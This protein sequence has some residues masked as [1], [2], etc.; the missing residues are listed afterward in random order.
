MGKKKPKKGGIKKQISSFI[1]NEEG[2]I[3]KH[4]LT[5]MGALV[6]SAAAAALI[7]KSVSAGPVSITKTGSSTSFT[8][9]ASVTH[10]Y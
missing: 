8:V 6:G 3:S 1:K 7:S 5:V 9:T 4:A 2:K 10:G